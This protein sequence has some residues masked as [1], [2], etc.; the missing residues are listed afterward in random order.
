M[1]VLVVWRSLLLAATRN[2]HLSVQ[3]YVHQVCRSLQVHPTLPWFA[4]SYF[5]H[6]LQSVRVHMDALEGKVTDASRSLLLGGIRLA[7][8][9]CSAEVN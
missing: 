9:C 4:I 8:A 1:Q 3:P 6:G 7:A 2:V 5:S